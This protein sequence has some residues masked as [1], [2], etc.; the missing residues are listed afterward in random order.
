VREFTVL[1]IGVNLCDRRHG[2]LLSSVEICVGREA[3]DEFKLGDGESGM[4]K[5]ILQVVERNGNLVVG[6]L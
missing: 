3:A 5:K 1:A 6:F 4:S 2:K